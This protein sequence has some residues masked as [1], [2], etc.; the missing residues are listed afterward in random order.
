MLLMVGSA[1]RCSRKK[2]LCIIRRYKLVIFLQVC[3]LSVI[4]F[5]AVLV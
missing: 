4:V 3:A 5:F 1:Y 2:S